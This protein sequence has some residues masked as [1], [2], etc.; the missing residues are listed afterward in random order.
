[1]KSLFAV[2]AVILL[3]AGCQADES[4]RAI[5]AKSC[6]TWVQVETIYD[7][8]EAE[9]VLS[10][11]TMNYWNA[12][13]EAADS[14]CANP[15]TATVASVTVVGI[16]V[17]RALDMA[18]AEAKRSGVAVGYAGD[19]KRLEAIRGELKRALKRE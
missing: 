1:M 5:L 10:Q 11:K 2:F 16:R 6:P 4:V 13:D 9:G 7:A 12:A 8:I 17:Y 14:L 15:Q 18:L 19:L 3:A